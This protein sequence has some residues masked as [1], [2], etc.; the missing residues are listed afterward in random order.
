MTSFVYLKN[1]VS[2]FKFTTGA[3]STKYNFRSEFTAGELQ[4]CLLN[5]KCAREKILSY[6][7]RDWK[8]VR[9][10]CLWVV[11]YGQRE[12]EGKDGWIVFDK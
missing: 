12:F 1:M 7:A 8:F 9:D 10:L 11:E 5:E 4:R 2:I 6:E 3:S